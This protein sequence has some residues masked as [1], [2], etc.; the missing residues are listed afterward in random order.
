MEDYAETFDA[1]AIKGQ[2]SL[3]LI[4]WDCISLVFGAASHLFLQLS[5]DFFITDDEPHPQSKS[6]KH[7][8]GTF[9]SLWRQKLKI[10]YPREIRGLYGW[11]VA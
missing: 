3:P 2:Y 5:L 10:L 4:T 8:K 11:N 6:H 9:S 1:F 7:E